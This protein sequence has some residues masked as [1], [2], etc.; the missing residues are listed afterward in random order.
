L[1]G[2]EYL[3]GLLLLAATVGPLALGARAMRIQLLPGWSGAPARLAES[4]AT[5]A[6]VV[7]VSEALGVVGAFTAGAIVPVSIAVGAALVAGLGRMSPRAAAAH[8]APEARP[9]DRLTT[10]LA[11]GGALLLLAQWGAGVRLAI[12]GGMLAT[13]TVWYHLPFGARFV[14]EGSIGG[15]QF[16]EIEPM[17]AYHPLNSELL[18]GVG[19]AL[20][21][22]HDVLSP[23]LNVGL[24]VLA[25]LGGWCIGRPYGVAPLSMLG[26]A[27]A[28][29]MPSVWANNAGQAGSDLPGL[30]F[31]VAAVGLLVSS[32]ARGPG[33]LLAGAAAGLALGS[34][35]TLLGPVVALTLVAVALAPRGRRLVYGAGWAAAAAAMGGV[36]FARNVVET[37]NPVPWRRLDLGPVELE[38]PARP[39]NDEFEFT[40]AHYLFDGEIWRSH[41]LP[42]LEHAGWAWP[43]VL[44]LAAAGA[45]GAVVARGDV[46]RRGLGALAVMCAVSYLVTP[47]S[48]AGPDGDPWTI[49]LNFRYAGP[50]VAIGLAVLPIWLARERGRRQRTVL[51][52]LLG[53]LVLTVALPSGPWQSR[54]DAVA[55]GL[56]LAAV[57][58]A[59][60]LLHR[61]AERRQAALAGVA[62]LCVAV[63]AGGFFV[64]RH[65][66]RHRYAASGPFLFARDL[67]D[68][69][70]GVFGSIYSYPLYGRELTNRVEFVGR[71]TAHGGFRR[72]AGCREWRAAV[73]EGRYDYVM[74]APLVSIN[75]DYGKAPKPTPPEVEWTRTD[76]AAVPV[77]FAPPTF[78]IRGRL[79]PDGC[80]A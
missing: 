15:L 66:E 78:V 10:W 73:N 75:V 47:N 32:R 18:H 4:V 11:L 28:I 67:H 38:A 16:F 30:S 71:R 35:L 17:S 9:A 53:T 13:D 61:V 8:P 72:L 68:K 23:F 37:G 5:I 50:P 48:A 43:A 76:P 69:R 19:M 52:A 34:K 21:S 57:A 65:Y 54:G 2:P 29:A 64:Q 45:I 60:V 36:W 25:L 46:I 49:G 51:A 55:V 27:I 79:D 1:T 24:V 33:G 20:M 12:R 58:G 56:G 41:I 6:L 63:L 77:G 26:T 31:F 42:G 39:L 14:Q 7:L 40:L 80:P 74:V 44:A 22:S 70:I 62:A 3:L 59:L